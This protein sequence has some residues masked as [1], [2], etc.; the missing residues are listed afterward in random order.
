MQLIKSVLH[1]IHTFWCTHFILPRG[2]IQQ[3][4]FL[5]SRFLWTGSTTQRKPAKIAW[6][7]ITLTKSEGGL[8]LKELKEWN[9]ALIMKHL[10]AIINPYSKSL[11]ADWVRKPVLKNTSFFKSVHGF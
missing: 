5:M 11:S 1:G 8:G 10:I 4:Q 9:K 2:I 7:T 6:S 3:L